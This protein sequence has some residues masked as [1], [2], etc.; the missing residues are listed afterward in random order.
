[1]KFLDFAEMETSNVRFHRQHQQAPKPCVVWLYVHTAPV[2]QFIIETKTTGNWAEGVYST[3]TGMIDSSEIAQHRILVFSLC[4]V[5]TLD[6]P[7]TN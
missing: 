3:N 4:K 2:S 1:M 5:T 6:A 7:I